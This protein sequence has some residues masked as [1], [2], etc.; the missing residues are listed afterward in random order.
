MAAK[1]GRPT[2][3]AG[4][5]GDILDLL[6]ALLAA[7]MIAFVRLGAPGVPRLLLSF[8]FAIF[9][10]GRAI[11]TNWPHLGRWSEAAMSMVFSLA[12][13]TLVTT[14]ALWAHYWHP[15][16]LTQVLAVLSLGGLAAGVVRRRRDRKSAGSAAPARSAASQRPGPRP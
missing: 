9:V 16:G 6:A 10:P 3:P 8:G 5:L 11:I 4:N 1:A 2:E 13:L 14:V 7:S 12:L 15:L